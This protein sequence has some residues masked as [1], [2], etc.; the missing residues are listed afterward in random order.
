METQ[1]AET[2]DEILI[3]IGDITATAGRQVMFYLPESGHAL[4]SS[5]A[6]LDLV[7]GYV[8]ARS[9]REA[10]WLFGDVDN[11]AR[12]HGPLVSLAQRLPSLI[13]LRQADADFSLP[14]T[15]AFVANDTG[16]LLL[17]DSGDRLEG[18][19]TTANERSRPLAARF[20]EAWERARPLAELRAL[21]I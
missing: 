13:R 3:A 11:L 6:L 21:G 2:Q 12:D 7:R 18:V 1:R 14:S 15:Q 19:F 16:R 10:C 8:T 20:D 9:H 5:P 4:W 17:I